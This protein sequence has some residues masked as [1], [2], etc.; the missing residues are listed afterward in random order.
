MTKWQIIRIAFYV[1][2]LFFLATWPIFPWHF[3]P[4]TTS[5]G[6]GG[7]AFHNFVEPV[8]VDF[9]SQ[10]VIYKKAFTALMP[11]LMLS[12]WSSFAISRCEGFGCMFMTV[13]WGVQLLVLFFLY[14]AFVVTMLRSYKENTPAKRY[15]ALIILGIAWLFYVGVGITYV[16]STH[17][18]RSF[19]LNSYLQQLQQISGKKPFPDGTVARD[20]QYTYYTS[21]NNLVSEFSVDSINSS[22][23][24][25]H[26]VAI[27]FFDRPQSMSCGKKPLY[28]T[29]GKL[30]EISERLWA[31]EKVFGTH[32]VWY[33]AF[34]DKS[35]KI[36][37]VTYKKYKNTGFSY[38]AE[39][40]LDS[41]VP[42]FF[43]Y[44]HL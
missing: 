32:E 44:Y 7:D 42:T 19:L 41:L 6:A 5:G 17:I 30:H 43:T 26:G 25:Q 22:T 31:C 23:G 35:Q 4:V 3:Y 14:M 24:E 1:T 39:Q 16:K 21:G 12:P 20:V 11:W 37:A 2:A 10:Q 27:F 8:S 13:V 15:K 36:Y 28:Y 18:N 33:A 38:P 29:D 9:I 34:L 40:S